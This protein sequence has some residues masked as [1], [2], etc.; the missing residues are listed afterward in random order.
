MGE[1]RTPR[2]TRGALSSDVVLVGMHLKRPCRRGTVM[3]STILSLIASAPL[4]SP[5]MILTWPSLNS[6]RMSALI[7]AVPEMALPSSSAVQVAKFEHLWCGAAVYN[8][9]GVSERVF[10][11]CGW[12]REDL[13]ANLFWRVSGS[14]VAHGVGRHLAWDSFFGYTAG[15]CIRRCT[16]HLLIKN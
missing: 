12:L 16:S 2:Q 10:S 8:Q 1:A 11:R 6:S 7:C 5:P 9:G 15:S 3:R 13:R 14:Y 4:Q